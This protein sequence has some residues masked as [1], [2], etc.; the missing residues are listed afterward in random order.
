MRILPKFHWFIPAPPLEQRKPRPC[1]AEPAAC[2][3]WPLVPRRGIGGIALSCWTGDASSFP[4]R[5]WNRPKTLSRTLEPSGTRSQRRTQ[6]DAPNNA[7]SDFAIRSATQSSGSSLAR[8]IES[9]FLPSRNADTEVIHQG[10]LMQLMVHEHGVVQVRPFG[11]G[12]IP[13]SSPAAHVPRHG[14][15][16]RQRDAS[17]DDH[18]DAGQ[19]FKRNSPNPSPKISRTV[20]AACVC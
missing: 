10:A 16:A 14:F 3:W 20:F 2:E 4:I 11:R 18:G 17:V 12:G 6:S 13:L 19:W 15:R 7:F 8:R 9:Y 1:S 5:S